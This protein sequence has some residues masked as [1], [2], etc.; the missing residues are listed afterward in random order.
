M[1]TTAWLACLALALALGWCGGAQRGRDEEM[2]LALALYECRGSAVESGGED[3]RYVRN[4]E[5]CMLANARCAEVVHVTVTRESACSAC[6][7]FARALNIGT[8]PKVSR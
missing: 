4:M 5:A 2:R 6:A 8:E 7:S 1:T 3:P